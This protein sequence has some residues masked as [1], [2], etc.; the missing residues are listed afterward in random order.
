MSINDKHDSSSSG[1]GRSLT[2]TQTVP[3]QSNGSVPSSLL[4]LH[5]FPGSP[6]TSHAVVISPEYS[7]KHT[8]NDKIDG[9]GS[10][11]S[12]C[13]SVGT[14]S[15][16]AWDQDRIKQKRKIDKS[17]RLDG[18]LDELTSILSTSLASD[19]D[20][21]MP[22]RLAS[23]W[24][25]TSEILA[26]TNNFAHVLEK[27]LQY[28]RSVYIRAHSEAEALAN[29][30]QLITSGSLSIIPPMNDD[31]IDCNISNSSDVYEKHSYL[32][33]LLVKAIDRIDL[34]LKSNIHAKSVLDTSNHQIHSV[35]YHD[36][37]S[38][39]PSTAKIAKTGKYSPSK[40]I[41]SFQCNL[42]Q[43]DKLPL[44]L[45]LEKLMNLKHEY[46]MKAFHL[47]LDQLHLLTT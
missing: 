34:L 13:D 43:D 46:M 16:L 18:S 23:D 26:E 1:R 21:T 9:G 36:P 32:E 35:D 14:S 7:R 27:R 31:Q 5:T 8:S 6:N 42:H 33:S 30:A 12:N 15:I 4:E 37:K 2:A 25:T 28:L 40:D 11:S 39:S 20:K 41:H 44:D 3:C 10:I 24:P 17:K 29:L 45:E 22:S 47:C 38:M 19:P